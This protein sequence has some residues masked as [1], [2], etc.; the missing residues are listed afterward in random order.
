LLAHLSRLDPFS[1]FPREIALRVLSHHNARSLCRAVQ[2]SRAWR[3]RADDDVLWHC[4]CE[5]HIGT[6]CH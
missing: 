1:V 4:I 3:A 6:R 2:V 5:Q